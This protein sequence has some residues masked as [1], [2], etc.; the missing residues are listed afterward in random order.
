[1]IT[2]VSLGESA[3]IQITRKIT[4]IVS[5]L[6]IVSPGRDSADSINNDTADLVKEA[7]DYIQT[8]APTVRGT[9]IV[10]AGGKA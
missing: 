6:I 1:V 4:E 2:R 5:D 7:S 9:K 3:K 8:I 10:E